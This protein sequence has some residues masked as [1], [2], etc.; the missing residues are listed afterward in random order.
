MTGLNNW[1]QWQRRRQRKMIPRSLQRQ[2]RRWLRKKKWQRFQVNVSDSRG[3]GEFTGSGYWWRRW[4]R[5]QSNTGTQTQ[6]QQRRRR[7]RTRNR[8]CVR[9]IGDNKGVGEVYTMGPRNL[10]RQQRHRRRKM[11]TNTTT[12]TTKASTKDRR[13]I[14]GT[15]D[16]DGGGSGSTMGLVDWQ[17]QQSVDFTC[18]LVAN[19]NTIS[20]L[21][22]CYLVFIL[23]SSDSFFIICCKKYYQYCN[24]A[25]SIFVSSVH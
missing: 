20:P 2:R 22:R 9:G 11:I 21:Y 16:N 25:E 23:F 6:Q 17:Q 5:R 14:Q 10:Q 15:E 3:A 8:Q 13:R 7:Q 1:R 24:H 12:T 4:S 19:I 18:Y